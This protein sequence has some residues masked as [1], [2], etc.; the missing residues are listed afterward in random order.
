MIPPNKTIKEGLVLEVHGYIPYWREKGQ[1]GK[2]PVCALPNAKKDAAMAG[3]NQAPL[4]VHRPEAKAPSRS[5]VTT[6]DKS[7]KAGPI[8]SSHRCCPDLDTEDTEV[9]ERN[10]YAVTI[11]QPT[12]S[13]GPPWAY[14]VSRST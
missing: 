5:V 3:A 12:R 6:N 10:Q 2:R 11:F 9:W 1:V 4:P 13:S 7:A 8:L 14:C